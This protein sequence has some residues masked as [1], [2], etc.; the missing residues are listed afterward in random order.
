MF[1]LFNFKF[2][3]LPDLGLFCSFVTRAERLLNMA[4]QFKYFGQD[5]E[6]MVGKKKIR[7]IHIWLSRNFWGLALYRLERGLFIL[8]GSPYEKIRILFSPLFYPIQAYSNID[9]H[10]KADIKGGI[11]VLHPSVGIVVSGMSVIG[12]N[13]TMVGGNIIGAKDRCKPGDIQVGDDCIMGAN[14]VIIGPINLGSKI[15]I[16]ASACVVHNYPDGSITLMGVPAK[17]A[18]SKLI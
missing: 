4:S 15:Y 17:P 13:L 14:A 3:T 8:L 5:V 2:A 10:Y 1:V 9:I 7:Y 16:A 12:R 6:R 18:K 11:S